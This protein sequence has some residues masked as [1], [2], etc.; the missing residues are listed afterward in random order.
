MNRKSFILG[1]LIGVLPLIAICIHSNCQTQTPRIYW[2]FK[3]FGISLVQCELVNNKTR[4]CRY[5][6]TA[7]HPLDGVMEAIH[8][9]T[10]ATDATVVGH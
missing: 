6:T 1:F 7:S 8:R 2:T 5:L 10:V 3:G 9:V 4:N